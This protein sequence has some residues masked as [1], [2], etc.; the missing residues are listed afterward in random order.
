M[1]KLQLSRI[2]RRS[3]RIVIADQPPVVEIEDGPVERAHALARPFA[4]SSLRLGKSPFAI[5]SRTFAT[6]TSTFNGGHLP[7]RRPRG[8]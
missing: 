8:G 7:Q 6:F 4:I 3:H 5:R 1:F 2:H